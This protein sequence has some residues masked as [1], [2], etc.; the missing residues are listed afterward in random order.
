MIFYNFY[1]S[2]KYDIY[3]NI[4]ICVNVK[5]YKYI[6]IYVYKSNDSFNFQIKRINENDIINV[7]NKI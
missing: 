6:F 5:T 1:L 7:I 4:K 2:I 3:F